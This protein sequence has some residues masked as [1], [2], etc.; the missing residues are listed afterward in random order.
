MTISMTR[1]GNAARATP[2]TDGSLWRMLETML[3]AAHLRFGAAA[4]AHDR[5]RACE[6]V[7]ADTTRDTGITPETATGTQNWQ[8]DLPFFMQSGFGRQ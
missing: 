3:R 4:R 2:D 8:A 1:T 5:R 7:G 6:A